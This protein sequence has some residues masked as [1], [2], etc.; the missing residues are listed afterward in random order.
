MQAK[1]AV[2]EDPA[3]IIKEPTAKSPICERTIVYSLSTIAAIQYSPKVSKPDVD[4]TQVISTLLNNIK[5]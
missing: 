1:M 4:L 3:E 2:E 5:R